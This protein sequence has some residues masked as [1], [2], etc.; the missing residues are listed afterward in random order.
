MK[1]ER[2]VALKPVMGFRDLL[3]FY[4][5]TGFSWIA[6]CIAFYVPLVACVLQLSSRFPAKAGSTS[7]AST[8]SAG[9]PGS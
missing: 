6:C 2:V 9:S 3:L 7:G 5:V 4:I 1:E 8:H